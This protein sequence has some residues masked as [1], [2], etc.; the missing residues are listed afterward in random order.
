MTNLA[1]PVCD[2][3]KQN[4]SNALKNISRSYSKDSS[5]Y[6]WIDPSGNTDEQSFLL[7]KMNIMIG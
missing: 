5:Y 2:I 6:V 4:K 1:K 7:V 3:S